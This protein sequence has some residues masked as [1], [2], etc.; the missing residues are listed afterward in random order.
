MNITSYC[1][2]ARPAK[3]FDI[4]RCTVIHCDVRGVSLVDQ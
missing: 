2:Y 3:C 4:G 1:S